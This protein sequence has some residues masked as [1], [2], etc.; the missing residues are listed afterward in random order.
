MAKVRIGTS[1]WHY[2]HWRGLFYP[3]GEAPSLMRYAERF[4]T[5]EINSSFYRLPSPETFEAWRDQ[6]PPGF[7]FSVKASRF[8]THMKKLRGSADSFERFFGA[9]SHLGEKLG[10]ILFQLPPRWHCDVERLQQFLSM[11]APRRLRCAFEFR[12]ETWFNP[13]VHD[14]LTRYNA[15]FC[16]YDI[17]HRRSPLPATAD[18]IYI[19]LHGPQATAYAG[20]YGET[21]LVQ[22]AKRIN[23]WRS[24]E[25][26]VFCYFDND[27]KAY[28]AD[29]ALRLK[30][31]LV[32]VQGRKPARVRRTAR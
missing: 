32:G 10:P 2:Q 9:T 7:L 22:W 11:L 23:A 26:D 24:E 3:P 4:D 14:L 31:I 20:S 5:V 29:D 18:F 15:A 25:R 28:A 19:R 17:A 13:L 21:A 12:D 30:A 8:I 27:Q 6:T 1:G 16:I